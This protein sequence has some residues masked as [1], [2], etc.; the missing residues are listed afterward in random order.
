MAQSAEDLFAPG[1]EGV[2][3]GRQFEM[4]QFAWSFGKE[5]LC[6]LFM[7]SEIPGIYPDYPKGW[8]GGNAPGYSNPAFDAA[9]NL[10]LT[11]L[12]DSEEIIQ[13]HQDAL[14]IFVEDLPV[15]PLYFRRD[16]MLVSP[17]IIGPETGNFM[18]LW[19]LEEYRRISE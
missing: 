17:E 1:P 18:L 9:C 14:K 19:N 6:K 3:F 11:S 5:S 7:S 12:P 13:A 16:V 10:A 8:G 2:V 4:A 15:L